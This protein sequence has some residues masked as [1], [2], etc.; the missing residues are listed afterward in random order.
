MITHEV[1]GIDVPAL[2]FGTWALRGEDC[3]ASVADAI[4]A[5]YRHIDTAARYGNEDAVG[6]GIRRGGVPRDA[7]FVTT[8]VWYTDLAPADVASSLDDSLR[9]LRLDHVDLALI[10]WPSATL[11]FEPALDALGDAARRGRTRLLGVSNF[12]PRLLRQAIAHAGEAVACNQV[13]YHPYLAQTPLRDAMTL[14]DGFLTAYAPL[15]RSRTA[16]D[17][18]L[19]SIG[20]AHGKTATQVGLRWLVQQPGVAAIP[21]AASPEHRRANLDIFDF[22]LSPEEMAAID[23]LDRGE[24]FVFPP[25]ASGRGWDIE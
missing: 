14:N 16:N 5:G 11:P 22:E 19:Q 3:A 2:G 12:T 17:P 4:A 8:K 6:E 9:R 20:A 1:H 7:L 15:A 10:H 21:K 13:E 23:E 24:R 18:L 25:W